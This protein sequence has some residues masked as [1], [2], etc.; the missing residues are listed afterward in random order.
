MAKKKRILVISLLCAGMALA[1]GQGPEDT[2][3]PTIRWA[4]SYAEGMAAAKAQNRPV[5]IKFS[6]EWCKW[7]E[8]MDVEVFVDV[9]VIQAL[10]RYTCI[11][12]DVDE[13]PDVAMA[14]SVRSLPRVMIINTHQE[15]VGDWLGYL[16]PDR[17]LEMVVDL[18]PALHTK[19]GTLM[20]P[21][22]ILPVPKAEPVVSVDLTEEPVMNLGHKDPKVREKAIALWIERGKEA[23]PE[24]L[25]HLEHSYLGVRIGAWKIVQKLNGSKLA[26]DPWAPLPKRTAMIKT[27]KDDLVLQP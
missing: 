6:A 27:L 15:I 25:G 12:V 7:C 13:R 11:K 2:P 5:L 24:I 1:Q 18:A 26:F 21:K 19:M 9:P 23:L 4:S 3:K 20:A 22:A 14:Y 17:F 16:R 8:R 10:Q